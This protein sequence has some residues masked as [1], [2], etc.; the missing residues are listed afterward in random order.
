MRLQAFFRRNKARAAYMQASIK[1]WLSRLSAAAQQ[2]DVHSDISLTP[3][4]EST[5]NDLPFR[6]RARA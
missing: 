3:T 5:L 6:L 2:S 4:A 1:L